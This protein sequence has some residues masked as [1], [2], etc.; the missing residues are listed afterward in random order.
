MAPT[1]RI[2]AGVAKA[3]VAGILVALSGAAMAQGQQASQSERMTDAIVRMI[4]LGPIFEEAARGDPNWPMQEKP[5]AV[6]DAQLACMRAELSEAGYRRSKR[7]EVE[8]YAQSN[9]SRMAAELRLLES[10][11]AELF[12]KLVAAGADSARAG[13]EVDTDAVLK[14][15]SP[16]QFLSFMTLMSDPNHAELRKLTGVGDALGISKSA[17]ENKDAGEQLGASLAVQHMIKSM[18][19][20]KVPLSAIL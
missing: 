16:E 3:T 1:R 9:P 6:S 18:G 12:G 10:G 19:T 7:A 20:C 15:A 13:I 8:A 17:D 14:S 4:P 5:G 11:A 2:F